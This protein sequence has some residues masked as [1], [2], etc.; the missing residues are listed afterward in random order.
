M[1]TKGFFAAGLALW[2]TAMALWP[3]DA[4]ADPLIAGAGL[5]D[6][7]CGLAWGTATEDIAGLTPAEYAWPPFSVYRANGLEGGRVLFG[8]AAAYLLVF[9]PGK[10]LVQ[11]R[12]EMDAAKWRSAAKWDFISRLGPPLII[13]PAPGQP[14]MP[15]W[16]IGHNTRV[17]EGGAGGKTV[18]I[19]SRRDVSGLPGV[20]DLTF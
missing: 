3:A 18:Y 16:H 13:E 11:G 1:S 2:L 5:A 12:V 19:F 17:Q 4:A 14:V 7:F 8:D 10:G 20:R 6:G 15:T 9:A